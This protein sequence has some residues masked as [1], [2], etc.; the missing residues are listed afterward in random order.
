MADPNNITLRSDVGRP[1]EWE[2]VDANFSELMSLIEEYNT[3]IVDEVATQ[4][5]IENLLNLVIALG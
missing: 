3:F 5:D 1:L 4:T 2:E